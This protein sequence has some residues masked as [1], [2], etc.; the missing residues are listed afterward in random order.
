MLWEY[1]I[2]V[3]NFVG[4]LNQKD[5]SRSCKDGVYIL[6]YCEFK[7]VIEVLNELGKQGW[8]VV[9]AILTSSEISESANFK[10]LYNVSHTHTRLL[11]K[12]PVT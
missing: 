4:Y 12:R 11:L 6:D 9:T 3:Y 8:E 2:F 7:E 10:V 1:M 5:R